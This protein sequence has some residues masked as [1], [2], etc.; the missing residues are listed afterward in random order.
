[1][2]GMRGSLDGTMTGIR[3]NPEKGHVDRNGVFLSEQ[4]RI[5]TVF[6][7]ADPGKNR[8]WAGLSTN[9]HPLILIIR[10]YILFIW[11]AGKLVF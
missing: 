11:Q 10:I 7:D 1:M 2:D 4:H 3:I 8:G 5:S 6:P 9:P